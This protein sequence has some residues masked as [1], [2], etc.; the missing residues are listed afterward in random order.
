VSSRQ[1]KT[2]NDNFYVL[3]R[4]YGPVL[5]KCLTLRVGSHRI[6]KNSILLPAEIF[7]IFCT[8]FWVTKHDISKINSNFEILGHTDVY[9]QL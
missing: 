4:G 6:R 1:L 8:A 3:I 9:F 7:W 2:K 5:Q